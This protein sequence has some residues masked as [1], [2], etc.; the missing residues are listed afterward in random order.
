MKM[1]AAMTDAMGLGE[2]RDEEIPPS[3]SRWQD[4]AAL[5]VARSTSESPKRRKSSTEVSNAWSQ[6]PVRSMP[7]RSTISARSS[8]G[9]VRKPWSNV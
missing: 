6:R 8:G 9:E 4:N 7:K 2:R 1:P 3:A 5:R